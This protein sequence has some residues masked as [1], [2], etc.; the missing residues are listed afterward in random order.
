MVKKRIC[1]T[2]SGFVLLENAQW[3]YRVANKNTHFSWI[4]TGKI[5]AFAR[6]SKNM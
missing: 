4:F 3:I 6:F 5:D 1:D 2:T